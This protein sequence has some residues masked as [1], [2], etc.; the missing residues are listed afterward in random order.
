MKSKNPFSGRGL[1]QRQSK[2]TV[3]NRRRR[4]PTGNGVVTRADLDF[5]RA[6]LLRHD[7]KLQI[8]VGTFL[9]IRGTSKNCYLRVCANDGKSPN[10][11]SRRVV[12]RTFDGF[13]W[14]NEYVIGPCTGLGWQGRMLDGIVQQLKAGALEETVKEPLP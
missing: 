13:R 14:L 6:G 2:P 12:L 9:E 5:L 1:A 7:K 11:L 4:A 10:Q 3:I 8:V